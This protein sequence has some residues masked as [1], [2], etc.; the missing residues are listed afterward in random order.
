MKTYELPITNQPRKIFYQGLIG[1]DNFE[2]PIVITYYQDIID[3]SQQGNGS[4]SI[5]PK[6]F[7]ALVKSIRKD[8]KK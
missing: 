1:D 6:A 8:L 5:L 4:I 7:E 2:N 3:L